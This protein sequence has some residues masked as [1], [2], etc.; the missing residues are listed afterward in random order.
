MI[1]NL[2]GINVTSTTD[3]LV[4]LFYKWPEVID[5]LHN[6]VRV[7]M[8]DF[9]KAFDLINH[10]ILITKYY[11]LICVTFLFVQQ[12]IGKKLEKKQQYIA[13]LQNKRK[14][15]IYLVHNKSTISLMSSW[16]NSA[17]VFSIR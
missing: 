6:Y 16:L 15:S 11:K 12:Y 9:M 14:T 4:E 17:S 8:L 10:R 3:A 13:L 5:K 7:V 2:G 1:S